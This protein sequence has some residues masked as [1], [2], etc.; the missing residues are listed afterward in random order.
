MGE[1]ELLNRPDVQIKAEIKTAIGVAQ[2]VRFEIRESSEQIMMRHDSYRLDMSI[3]RRPP[4]SR[5]SYSE[6]WSK[7]RYERLGALYMVPPGERVSFASEPGCTTSIVCK[8]CSGSISQWLGEHFVWTND[9]LETSLDFPSARTRGLLRHLGEELMHPGFAQEV[10][11]ELTSAQLALEVSRCALTIDSNSHSSGLAP[12]R[13]RIIDERVS[14]VG[15]APTLTELANLC[16]IS[17]RQLTRGFKLSR[18][19]SIG[20]FIN[21]QRAELAKRLLKTD[22]TIKAIARD[23]NFGTASSFTYAFR[24]A[25]GY[26]PRA[27]RSLMFRT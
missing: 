11:V 6:H 12:W 3:T 18:G 27:F 7:G 10:M 23:L 13:L 24:K 20:H 8:L 15:T 16:H 2:I 17:V 5:A 22:L 14:D 25:T 19:C 21:Q 26:T 9:A 4:N 1:Y